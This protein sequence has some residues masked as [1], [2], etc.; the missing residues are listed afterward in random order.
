MGKS[1]TILDFFKRKNSNGSKA[2]ASDASLP[3]TNV[4]IP[5]PEDVNNPILENF[6]VSIPENVKLSISQFRK[7]LKQNFEKLILACWSVIPDC[8]HKY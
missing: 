8:V 2:N 3:T 6:D 1:T 4:D 5:I 7:I